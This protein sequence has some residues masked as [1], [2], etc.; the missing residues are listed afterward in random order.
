MAGFGSVYILIFVI[1]TSLSSLVDS[2]E[3]TNKATTRP[4]LKTTPIPPDGIPLPSLSTTK[5]PKED[6]GIAI[7][8]LINRDTDTTC[9]LLRTD[10]V[11]EVKFK[12]HGIDVQADSFIPENAMVVGDCGREEYAKMNLVW[13]GYSL[14]LSFAKT[15]G[16]EHWYLSNVELT[17]SIDIPQFHGI[18]TRDKTLRLYNN[19]MVIP[20]PVGKSYICDQEVDVD[21]RT[22]PVDRP[23]K[24]VHGTLLLRALQVQAFMYRSENFSTTFECKAQRSFRS[25]TAP[26]AVGS[27]LA[28]AALATVTGYG[29]FRYLKVKNVQYNTME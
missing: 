23:P 26:I 28:V 10:A 9:I 14:T 19:S 18:K 16:G 27:T 13:S 6:S 24:D 8:R 5:N 1:C 20:T 2:I 12:L 4:R 11:V 7:Y 17:V 3:L 29:V 25:E 15:P 21:L 22:D